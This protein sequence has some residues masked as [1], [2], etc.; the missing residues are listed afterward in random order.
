MPDTVAQPRRRGGERSR[1]L[2]RYAR[3]ARAACGASSYAVVQSAADRRPSPPEQGESI[4][5][6]L[7]RWLSVYR[8][9]SETPAFE[10]ALSP[11]AIVLVVANV[12]SF[13]SLTL[14]VWRGPIHEQQAVNGP[15]CC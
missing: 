1:L 11:V 10:Y 5:A 4:R 8:P 3:P 15:S 13:P 12:S 9:F 6:R 2:S 14:T 7:E